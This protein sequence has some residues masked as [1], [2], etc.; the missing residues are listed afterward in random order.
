MARARV[1]NVVKARKSYI[2]TIESGIKNN[3]SRGDKAAII[4]EINSTILS[5]QSPVRGKSFVQYSKQYAKREK[6]GRRKPV[7]MFKTGK[8][9]NSLVVKQERGF[10]GL[11]IFF[12]DPVAI[13][14]DE[15]GAGINK[16][17]RRLL[18][19]PSQ[20]ESFKQNIQ[21][22]IFKVFRKAIRKTTR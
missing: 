12:K 3:I 6:G 13:F 7:R 17:I 9:L 11:V 5:G 20:G 10:K 19:R 8:M 15:L 22:L 21:A 2:E 1:K 4:D 14:H 16:V 18:P